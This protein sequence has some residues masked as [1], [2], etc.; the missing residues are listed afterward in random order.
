MRFLH[1]NKVLGAILTPSS[2]NANYPVI[3][4]K[5]PRL[6]RHFRF[7]DHENENIVADASGA[8]KASYVLIANHN[9]SATATI[10]LQGNATDNWTDPTFDETLAWNANIIIKKFTEAEYLYWRFLFIDPDNVDGYVKLGLL[11]LGVYYEVEEP[12][13]SDLLHR[14]IDTTKT[15]FSDSGQAYSKIGIQYKTYAIKMGTLEETT[16]QGLLSLYKVVGLHGH[17]FLLLDEN[18][19]DKLPVVYCKL[20][21]IFAYRHAGGYLWRDE[22][23]RFRE[24]F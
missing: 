11:Y 1:D 19:Q 17:F 20:E 10:K 21:K 14:E 18:N 15:S 24:V 16:R 5:D 6:S 13:D 23:M 9:L 7:T 22:A 2:E 12:P 4:L 8:L 3:N